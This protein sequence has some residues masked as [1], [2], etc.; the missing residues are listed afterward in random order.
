MAFSDFEHKECACDFV[1][2][3]E[4][5]KDTFVTFIDATIAL[6]TTIKAAIA[7]WPADLGDQ[8]KKVGLEA[9][10]LALETI[11]APIEAPFALVNNYFRPYSDCPP[12]VTVASTVNSVRDAVL[13]PF[14]EA[15]QDIE[16]YTAALDL[17]GTKV[18]KLDMWINQLQD[19][20]DAITFCGT[21]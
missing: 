20:K 14:E 15:K 10:L 12:V 2:N 21:M 11:M 7:L 17:E 8:V 4:S 19:F 5:F 16:D 13:G 9:S 6:L 1:Q 3:L 18:A